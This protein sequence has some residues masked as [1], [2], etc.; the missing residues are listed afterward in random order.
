MSIPRL[1]LLSKAVYGLPEVYRDEIKNAMLV[2]SPGCYP[3]AF[4]CRSFLCCGKLIK[5]EGI[6]ADSM[7]G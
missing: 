4:F 6:I 1:S 3:P 7:S 2:A 5:P